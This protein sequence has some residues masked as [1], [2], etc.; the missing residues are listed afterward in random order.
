[1]VRSKSLLDAE[2]TIN[3]ELKRI[4]KWF[5]SNKLA[6]NTSKTKYI[7]FRSP[8][9]VHNTVPIALRIR[10]TEISRVETI[11]Y[12]GVVLDEALN[13]RPHIDNLKKVLRLFCTKKRP[14][15]LRF[16][17]N[18]H[19]IFSIFPSNLSYCIKKGVYLHHVYWTNFAPSKKKKKR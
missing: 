8:Y 17:D 16:S 7:V 13:W 1:M 11:S 10:D 2:S 15:S 12:L 6:L 18:A 19:Y 3:N 4:H 5:V 9:K 14:S